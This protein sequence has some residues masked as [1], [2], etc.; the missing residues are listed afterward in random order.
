MFKVN[1]LLPIGY[2]VP[3]RTHSDLTTQE[4]AMDILY[5]LGLRVCPKLTNK[6][7]LTLL[8]WTTSAVLQKASDRNPRSARSNYVPGR[9]L[10]LPVLP[11]VLR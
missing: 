2:Y 1:P 4:D 3:R 8:Q 6:I 10:I 11:F 9:N 7:L 5:G